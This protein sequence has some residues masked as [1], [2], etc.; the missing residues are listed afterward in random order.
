[1]EDV[2]TDGAYVLYWMTGTRRTNH[3]FGLQRAADVAADLGVPLVVFEA[4]R[5]GYRWASVRHH[6]FILDGMRDNERRLRDVGVRY[7]PYIEREPDDGAGLLERLA[8]DAC[9]VVTDDYPA[10]FLPRMLDAVERRLAVRL[11]RVDSNGLWPMRATR[12]VFT[13]AFSFRRFLQEE[14]PGRLSVRPLEDPLAG[15]DLPPPPDFGGDVRERWPGL[16]Q[17][18]DDV[19]LRDI[20][21]DQVPGTGVCEG[22]AKAAEKRLG[23]FLDAGFGAYAESR[24]HPD[25]DATSGLSPYL[26]YG[27]ISPHRIFEAIAEREGWTPGDLGEANGKRSG[28]WGMS[29]PAESFLDEL[30]TWRELGFNA[31]ALRDD[32]DRYESLPEWARETIEE[33]ADDPRPEVY[34]ME[35]LETASTDDEVWNAA[36]RQLVSEGRLHNYLRMLWG[37]KIFEWTESP[38]E[39]LERMIELNNRYALDGRDPNSYSGIFWTLGRYDRA[40]GPERPIYGKI[41]YM[42]SENTKRKLRM[43]EYLE[44]YGP[45]LE[46]AI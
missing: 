44:R 17:G 28:W 25:D 15:L 13:R 16:G 10:F 43:S 18:A 37:K 7:V 2:R 8:E 40:W 45:Q 46:L 23:A 39:A 32:Y 12:R 31:C 38:E 6:R 27:H 20:A 36:Q 5:A 42:T 24:N 9:L 34:E 41:R 11:E 21:V 4:L 3:H 14:L 1:D 33:H 19:E 30:V 26:H 22:G 35:E 29:E